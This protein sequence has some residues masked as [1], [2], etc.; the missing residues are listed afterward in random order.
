MELKGSHIKI[1]TPGKLDRCAVGEFA[2]ADEL[3]VVVDTCSEWESCNENST[4]NPK[5]IS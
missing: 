3:V 1:L 5:E 4:L 2:V